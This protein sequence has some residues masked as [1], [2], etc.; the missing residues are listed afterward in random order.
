MQSGPR[1]GTHRR[2]YVLLIPL[3]GGEAAGHLQQSGR[4]KLGAAGDETPGVLNPEAEEGL[5]TYLLKR[6]AEPGR[7]GKKTKFTHILLSG[8]VGTPPTIHA[9]TADGV[10]L[11]P[12]PLVSSL[13]VGLAPCYRPLA[14]HSP[15]QWVSATIC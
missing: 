13:V 4:S 5:V 7:V 12:R 9:S 15:S 3:Q 8:P 2:S 11:L 6:S 1:L 10:H 14:F